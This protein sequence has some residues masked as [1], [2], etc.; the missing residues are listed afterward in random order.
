VHDP[1]HNGFHGKSTHPYIFVDSCVQMWPDTDWENVSECG[2][3]AYAITAW[4]PW[5][6]AQ[7]AF[8][9]M[10]H[11]HSIVRRH[12]N[13]RIAYT[14]D[15]IIR[16]K[17]ENQAALIITSQAGDFLG[18]NLD[19]LELFQKLGLRICIPA[20]N[21]RNHL[22]DGCIE[23][24]G[25]G[26]SLLG[27]KWVEECNRLGVL[28]DCTHTGRRASLEIMDRSSEPVVFTHSNPSAIVENPRNIT[29][30][31]IKRCAETGGVIAPTNW[32]PLNFRQ[33]MTTRPALSDYLFA[34]DYIVQLVGIDHAGIG[35]DMSHGSYPEGDVVPSSVGGDYS[36]Y[37]TGDARSRLRYVEGFD[38]YN[39]IAG[40]AGALSER[41]YK[42]LDIRKV[43]GG[44]WLRVFSKVWRR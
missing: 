27:R 15:D 16:A 6:G 10:A 14:A 3:T 29:D 19:R 5:D 38:D 20:Y 40:V 17:E 24:E 43:L 1:A 26:L 9:E 18:T 23:P 39:Q 44:N 4:E 41:G 33:G 21:S 30:E 34:I 25:A 42:D 2:C 36:K 37:V 22:C 35:T 28:I 8:D 13:L 32:G 31:Q 11:W 7:K 12:G